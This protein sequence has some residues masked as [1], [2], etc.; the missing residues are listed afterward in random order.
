[1]IEIIVYDYINYDSE[2][3]CDGGKYGFSTHYKQIADDKWEVI[4]STT[5][6]FTYC[7]LCGSFYSNECTCGMTDT[8]KINTAELNDII[9]MISYEMEEHACNLK[10]EIKNII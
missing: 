8:N 1:M 7:P 9:K 5:S 4:H 2:F 3:C 6:D 10:I